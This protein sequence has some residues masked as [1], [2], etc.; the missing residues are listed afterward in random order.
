MSRAFR[1]ARLVLGLLICLAAPGR[2]A[3]QTATVIRNNGDSANRVDIAIIGDGYTSAEIAS[4]K[5]AADVESFVQQ[6]FLQDPY[7]E[8]ARYYNVTR[9]DIASAESGSDHPE[10]GVFKDTALDSTYNTGGVQRCVTANTSKVNAALTTAGVVGN[11]R[12]TVLVIVNDTEYGGCG[13]AIAVSSIH[14]SAV[15]IILHELGHSFALLADEYGGPPPPTCNP[16]EPFEVNATAQTSR[17]AIKW[18]AWIDPGTP[19]PT[20]GTTLG[21]PGLYAGARYCDAGLYRPTY[22]S[23]MRSLD[24]PFEV[25]NAEQHVRRIYNLVSPIDSWAPTG[26]VTVGF[27]VTQNFSVAVPLPATHSLSVSW[28]VDGVGAGTGPLFTAAGLAVG[29]HQIVATVRDTTPMVRSDPTQLLVDTHSWDVAVTPS[30]VVLSVD[31]TTALPGST[32]MLTLTAGPGG[33]TDWIALARCGSSLMTYVSWF[34][35]GAGVTSHTW[36]VTMPMALG[37][38]EFRLFSNNGFT[39]LS[40]SSSIDVANINPTP[41]ITAINPASIAAGSAAFTLTVTGTGFVNG[42]SVQVDGSVRPTTFGTAT[43]L[44][45]ALP[46]SDVTTAGTSHTVTVV[47][48]TPCVASECTS[49]GATLSVTTPPAAPTITTIS[50]TSVAAGGAAFTLTVTGTDFAGNSVVQV[51]GSARTTT[52]GSVTSL[53]ATVPA[54]DIASGGTLNVTV[55]TPAPG[56]GTSNTATLTVVGPTLVVSATTVPVAGPVQTTFSNG[57]GKTGEWIALFPTAMTGI[58]GYVDWQWSTGGQGAGGAATT[59]T[60]TFPTGG[61]VFSAGTYVFRWISGTTILAQSPVVS[62]Q[63]INP[64]PTVTAINPANIAAGSATFTLT[65]TGTGFV[66]GAIVQVDG[67]ARPTTFGTATQ[68]TAALP[69]SDVTTAGT[70]HTIT[71]VNPPACVGSVCTSNGATLS[72]TT[73]P[74]APTIT[75]ISPTSAAAGGAAFTLTVTG[76]DFAGNSVVQANGSPRPTTFGNATSL[77]ATIAASD[78]ASGGTLNITVVTPAPGGGTSNAAPLTVIG[79]ALTV[80]ATTVPVAGPV[81]TSFSNGPGRPSEWVA[82]FP[83][84]TSGVTGYVDWQW[85]TGGQASAGAATS[86]TLTF[87]TGGKVLTV[88][89]YVFRWISTTNTVL[90]QSPVVSFQVINPTPTIATISPSGVAAGSSDFT[91]TVNGAGYVAG[92]AVQVDGSARATTFVSAIKVTAALLAGDVTTAGTGHTI[93]VVNPSACVGSVCTSNGA[94]LSVTTPPPTPTITSISPTTVAAG[95]GAFTLTVTGTDFAGNSVVQVNGS[96]RTTTIGSATS[97]SATVLASDIASGGTLNIT[98]FTPAPGGGSSNTAPLTVV[99]PGLAVNATTVP[100]AGPV[101]TT[102]SN[103]PGKPSEW[104][105]LYPT[106]TTGVNG[107]VDWQWSTGGQGAGGAATT[108]TLTF[109]TGGKVLAPGT[110]VFR[111]ISATSTI[112]AQSPVVSFQVINPTPTVAAISPASIA[113]GNADFTLSVTG[114]GFVS[115]AAVQVN[116]GS[117]TT[118]FVSPF[119]VSAALLASDVT[120]AGTSPTITVVNPSACVGGLCTSNGVPLNV[121]TPPAA[122]TITTINPT[123]VASGG[124][125]FTLEVTGT[126]FAGNSVVQV[127]GNPRFTT[128][129]SATSL[130]ATILPSDIATG[131]TLTITVMTPAPG[132]GTSNGAPLTVMG[133]S[134]TVNATTVPVVGPVQVTFSTGPGKS[135]E[136]IALYPASTTGVGGYVDWQW[137]TGG[138]VAAGAATNGVLTFPTGGRTLAPGNYVF[139]WISATSTILAQSPVV[140]FQV[141]NP[142]PTVAAINP[143][144]VAAG[145]ADFALSVTG[146]GFVSGAVVQVNGSSRTTTFVSPFQVSAALLASDVTTAGTSHVVTVVNPSACA[147]GV[148]TSNGFTLN[149]TTPPAAPTI[150]TISPT[151]VASGGSAFILT[152][153]GT[154]FA[155]NS[156]VQVNGSPR[157]TFSSRTA[158]MLQATILPSDIATGGTLTITVMTPAPGGGTSN[159]APLTVMGPV[160]TVSLT[161]AP[162]AGPVQAIFSTGPGQPSEWIGLFPVTTSGTAGYVDWQWITGGQSVPGAATSGT[163][164]FPTGGRSVPT[165]SYVFRWISSTN[166]VLAQSPVVSFQPL[167]PTPTI[168]QLSRV[169]V[170]AGSSAFSLT[171]TGTGFI[172]GATVQV[173]GM[174]RPTTVNSGTSVAAVVLASDLI[175]AGTTRTVTVVNPAPCGSSGCTSNGATLNVTP[176]PPAPTI[177]SLDRSTIPLQIA[178]PVTVTGTNI[179]ENTFFQVN[180]SLRATTHVAGN[181]TSLTGLLLASDVATIGTLNITLFTPA[182]GGGASNSVS[183][184]VIGPQLTVSATTVV[185]PGSVQVTFSNGYG[186]TGESIGMYPVDSIGSAEYVDWQWMTGG[187]TSMGVATNGTLTFPTAGATIA[188]GAYVFRWIGGGSTLAQTPVVTFQVVSPTPT[189]AAINPPSVADG[190]TASLLTATGSGFANG[191]VV[192]VDGSPRPTMFLSSTSVLAALNQTDVT[193]AGTSPTITVVNPLPCAAG[194][195]VSN[196]ATLAITASP[197]GPTLIAINPT[198]VAVGGAAFTLTATGTDFA[199]NSVVLVNGTQ[200]ATTF[201]GSTSLTATILTSDIA[202]GGTLNITVSTPAPGGGASGAQTLTVTG[203][204]LAVSATSVAPGSTITVTLTN[205]LGGAKDWLAFASTASPNTSWAGFVYPGAGVTSTT[206][207]VTAPMTPGSY[208]FRLFENDGFNRLSTSPTITVVNSTLNLTYRGGPVQHN[209][210]VYTIFWNST[211]TAFPPKYQAKIN[212]FIKDLNG[213]SYYAIASQYRDS[214]GP[215]STTLMFVGTWLDTTNAIPHNPPTS[216]DLVNEVNRAMAAN[217]WTSDANSYFQIYTPSGYGTTT[218]YCGFHQF[219]N[220]A[221]GLILFPA[222]HTFGTCIPTGGFAPN[223][224]FVDAAINTTAHEI[225]EALTD[226]LG[227]AW[228]NSTGEEIADICNFQ[229]GARA[230]DGSNITLAGRKYL[231]QQQWSNAQQACVLSNTAPPPPAAPGDFVSSALPFSPTPESGE[232]PPVIATGTSKLRVTAP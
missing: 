40:A 172:A 12:D 189:L 199:P 204:S 45:A 230:A 154:N 82:L 89:P 1:A 44:T 54:G 219:T 94:T 99:G 77:T 229:F 5:Y 68:L 38:Y 181:T 111:W 18:N 84:N 104:I 49:N 139:R 79:P 135:N 160:L 48:P 224:V 217:G 182:P 52:F 196:G 20:P 39:E 179:A 125:A 34:Y 113:A 155:G 177:T 28:T 212:Q 27:G 178:L 146:T 128:F 65:V 148:C 216:A 32:V 168:L 215:I 26:I 143:A 70:S 116:G 122:P 211:A 51:N 96:G 37:C 118:T 192:Q 100:V 133:P 167:N 69:A 67:S 72:V 46:A 76:T 187:Q 73:P 93:T 59:G 134:L 80:S 95:G 50:P 19:V 66:N 197:A 214:S 209:Q 132:G 6:M 91:L 227:N 186:R 88:G 14:P 145:S 110:Y 83:A 109:P 90:A 203:P 24:R 138:Q 223:D 30:P 114:T 190:S 35:A 163:L 102:F 41:V 74:A 8:Y 2:A 71:V 64:T 75:T 185:L 162:L 202:S 198:S 130:T 22:N 208:Q 142:T 11:A 152:V 140:S 144:S 151:F 221:V 33:P 36:P 200:R 43:Q 136:W 170:A 183:L 63:V 131:G 193:T 78:I 164:T 16:A 103:G 218:A 97:L 226:P 56:G 157:F 21:L 174:S 129:G 124:P 112:L 228:F 201:G 120:T 232:V 29:S 195:C 86:G 57:P 3:A 81:Q 153:T 42:A 175:T 31:T 119:Q 62:F 117:R 173:D 213:S 107:Y 55:F 105:A 53:T 194:G 25:I 4:G 169:N 123:F 10:K 101:Q 127:N 231:V 205:G 126:N 121:T 92:A 13:G 61:K 180:G 47:N 206:W 158:T 171:V 137:V 7:R 176:P 98:V 115:G 149:V 108:G 85:T 60:L 23:K 188:P 222:D 207:T 159:G 156:V 106:A 147:G 166:T 17:A 87:P 184:P 165:G 150:T 58:T 141:I 210:K 9:V 161:A 15:E 225:L 220:P 191:A